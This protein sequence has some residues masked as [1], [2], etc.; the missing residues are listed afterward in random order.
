MHA[1]LGAMAKLALNCTSYSNIGDV[2][3]RASR[4]LWHRSTSRLKL[5]AQVHQE[6]LGVYYN[7]YDHFY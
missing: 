4:G 6:L 2:L 5:F 3:S 1:L 7:Y